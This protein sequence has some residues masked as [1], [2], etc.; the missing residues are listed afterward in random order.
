MTGDTRQATDGSSSGAFEILPSI[1]H[2]STR[3]REPRLP[4]RILDVEVRSEDF[5]GRED[6]FFMMEKALLPSKSKLIS[7]E[8]EGLKQFALC[9]MG[10]LGKTEIATEFTVR[11]KERFDAVFWIRA[12][13]VAKMDTCFADIAIRLGLEDKVESTNQIVSR[14]LVKG[15]LSDPWEITSIE[16]RPT[17]TPA[18]WLIIFDNADDQ[19]ALTDYWPLQGS[20]SVLIT[21]RDPMAKTFFSTSSSGLDLE[22]FNDYDGACMLKK[23][24]CDVEQNDDKEQQLAERISHSL[25]G[26]P[27]AIVQTAGVIRRQDLRLAEF[28]E[29][30]QDASKHAELQKS[31]FALNRNTYPHIIFSV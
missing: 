29:S 27:L 24:L 16:S 3:L 15:W 28:L 9:G 17:R 30:Y 2:F 23:L 19:Y 22:P 5:F 20:G 7:S 31:K 25:G 13:G 10:G 11:Y 8:S 18:T 12:E 4:C 1:S 14:E 21:S 6:V 26:L